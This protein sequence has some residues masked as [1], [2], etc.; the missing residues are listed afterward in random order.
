MKTT[1]Q[2]GI[3]TRVAGLTLIIAMTFSPS[4]MAQVTEDTTEDETGM[5]IQT[6]SPCKVE[7]K[8]GVKGGLNMFNFGNGGPNQ[9]FRKVGYHAGLFYNL[10]LDH[11]IGFRA[12][13]L[14]S[15]KGGQ[16]IY[17]NKFGTGIANF[18]LNYVEMPVLVQYNVLSNLSLQVGGYAA[19]LVKA[20]VSRDNSGFGVNESGIDIE[21]TIRREHFS[22]LDLGYAVGIEYACGG[23]NFGF[24]ITEGIRYAGRDMHYF[25]QQNTFANFRNS[26][27]QVSVGYAF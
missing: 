27:R 23:V 24:R 19:Y 2:Q 13:L 21:Q 16:V 20:R 11:T 14:A 12:E 7:M 5:E 8:M 4:L 1:I 17:D 15:N 25:G 6:P 22:P 18:R 9:E 10:R 3:L 26:V